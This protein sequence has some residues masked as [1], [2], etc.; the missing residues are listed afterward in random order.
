MPCEN[1]EESLLGS[2][3]VFLLLAE[4]IQMLGF[5]SLVDL[6]FFTTT[7]RSHVLGA[8]SELVALVGRSLD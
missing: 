2:R 8:G 7:V 5:K 3:A 4:C 6:R 1:N